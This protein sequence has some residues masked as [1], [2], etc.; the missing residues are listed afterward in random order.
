MKKLLSFLSLLML[1]TINL[2]AQVN[3]QQGSAQFSLPVFNFSDTKSGL[4]HQVAV[5][6]SSGNGLKV[7]SLASDIGLGWELQAGGSIIRIQK[8]EPDDQSSQLQFPPQP[9]YSTYGYNQTIGLGGDAANLPVVCTPENYINNYFPNGFLYSEFPLDMTDAAPLK[10]A[11]PKEL[12][13]LP[14]FKPSMDKR[15][16]QSRRALTDR[17]QDLFILSV[18]GQNVEFVIGKNGQL[19]TLHNSRMTVTAIY[20]TSSAWSQ[21][22]RTTISGFSVADENGMIYEFLQPDYSEIL[23]NA[24]TNGTFVPAPTEKFSLSRTTEDGQGKYTIDKWS[25]TSI[26]NT[27][28]GEKISF[29]YQL[30]PNEN[31]SD[32]VG[33][34]LPSYEILPQNS[35]ENVNLH[36]VR[37]KG[38]RYRLTQI[39]FPNKYSINFNY[40]LSANGQ[41]V[42]RKDLQGEPVLSSI[43]LKNNSDALYANQFITK[44]TFT[45][46]YFYKKEIKSLDDNIV[47]ADKRYLRLCLKS[48]QK[49]GNINGVVTEESPYLFTYYTGQES[50][51]IKDIVPPTDCFAQDHW[52]FYN[53]S[54]IVDNSLATPD[55]SVLRALMVLD[56]YRSPEPGAATLGLLRSI[57]NPTKGEMTYEYEQNAQI[58]TNPSG[59]P[60][61]FFTGGVHVS[62]VKQYDG[63]S[64]TNDIVTNY[65]YVLENGLS[66]YWGYETPVYNL[67]RTITIANNPTG[68]TSGGVLYANRTAILAKTMLSNAINSQLTA[69]FNA[70]DM[71]S[72]FT[73]QVLAAY[74]A[75]KIISKLI[76]GFFSLISPFSS[77]LNKSYQFYP[78]NYNNGIGTHISRVEI[79]NSSLSG[80]T[81]KI[82]Q[83]FT[84][85]ANIATEILP[86]NFPYSNKQR[87]AGWEFD[88]IKGEKIYDNANSLIGET[89]YGYTIF[90]DAATLNT[91]DFR[92]CKVLPNLL[93]SSP[94]DGNLNSQVIANWSYEFYNP[95]TG[96]AQ[97][98]TVNTKKYTNNTVAETNQAITYTSDY[99]PRSSE[100]TNSAG[101]RIITKTYYVKDYADAVN[102]AIALLKQKGAIN[103]PVSTET[104]LIK[105]GSAAEYLVGAR[106]NE[107]AVLPNNSIRI[108]KI[109]SLEN[110]QPVPY[111]VIQYQTPSQLIRNA[112]YFTVQQEFIYDATGNLVETKSAGNKISSCLLDY[113][114]RLPTAKVQNAHYTEFAYT[115]FETQNK[116]NWIYDI[117]G[118]LKQD[119]SLTG[120]MCFDLSNNRTLSASILIN[121]DYI[122]SFWA[123]NSVMVSGGAVL[124]KS[125]PTVGNW[126][127]YEYKLLQGTASPVITG[128]ANNYIDE[129]RLYPAGSM[130]VTTAYEPVAGNVI[131]ECDINNT[132]TYYEYDGLGRLVLV[133]D[134][135]RNV[136]K[137]IC[138]NYSGQPQNCQ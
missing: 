89:N 72:I 60:V 31:G 37:I 5:S 114:N 59:Q 120:K 58:I 64:H 43:I 8:G 95:V 75:T 96:R 42:Q 33:Q 47:D 66:S 23:K 137:K 29:S 91:N 70:G 11:A 82:V 80:G 39:D 28:T 118:A 4:A 22:I 73:P 14:R 138:Y 78:L 74:V 110:D 1:S 3:V 85:P 10:Y 107:Y 103:T 55:K 127:Y 61:N 119:N 117:S 90:K 16:K 44:Y 77:T 122:L 97:L 12:A 87:Y 2:T 98:N 99:Q 131:S 6:Y 34:I 71:A 129:L 7:N 109:Y 32:F 53:K 94:C 21:N 65:K 128:G 41:L 83:E 26:I 57:V 126:T 108:M 62:K 102:P 30:L 121:K 81:G 93:F 88:Q 40:L 56:S 105:N 130:M 51:S 113:Q 52:G 45:Q 101:D 19:V 125:G 123:K 112:Q 116:G 18:N 15:W 20:N 13:F 69:M 76:E 27:L 132:V 111:S 35:I 49:T 136:L 92:S 106:I 133:K 54:N 134:K 24:E 79:S 124:I 84:K 115:S 135:D 17:E 48:V 36:S 25:L 100:T 86:N 104:W 38:K 9:Y 46:G 63:I 50:T 67:S 68:Y